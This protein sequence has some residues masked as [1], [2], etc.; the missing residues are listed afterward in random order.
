MSIQ[1]CS[2]LFTTYKYSSIHIQLVVV[3]IQ[4]VQSSRRIMLRPYQCA[5]QVSSQCRFDGTIALDQSLAN[6]K[7]IISQLCLLHLVQDCASEL[8]GGGVASHVACADGTRELSV[9]QR[10]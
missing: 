10:L 5:L 3:Q 7:V 4:C 2:M 1:S 8:F 6:V 9:G